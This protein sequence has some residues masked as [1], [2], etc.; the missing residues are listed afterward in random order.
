M[1]SH[2]ALIIRPV[3]T[4]TTIL[5]TLITCVC[6][7]KGIVT[8]FREF[9]QTGVKY[10][11]IIPDVQSERQF[12]VYL[13]RARRVACKVMNTVSINEAENHEQKQN[14]RKCSVVHRE[15]AKRPI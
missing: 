4:S 6:P 11:S 15:D 3:Y 1:P 10:N 7:F 12:S 13:Q 5:T 8:I 9:K 14:L 2:L